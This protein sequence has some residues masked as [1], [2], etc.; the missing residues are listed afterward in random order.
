MAVQTSKNSKDF[1]IAYVKLIDT[2]AQ[3]YAAVRV[4]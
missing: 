4:V 2:K 3:G 1:A